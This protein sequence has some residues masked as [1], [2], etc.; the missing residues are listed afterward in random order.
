[1]NDSINGIASEIPYISQ[2]VR[3]QLPLIKTALESLAVSS[4]TIP[5]FRIPS[6]SS[7]VKRFGKTDRR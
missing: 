5:S 3:D 6:E 4:F 1:M 7:I 2:S